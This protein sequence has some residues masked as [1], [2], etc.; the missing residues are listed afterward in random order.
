MNATKWFYSSFDSVSFLFFSLVYW[1]S[2][3]LHKFQTQ[4][5]NDACVFAVLALR[6]PLRK[7][8]KRFMCMLGNGIIIKSLL[9]CVCVGAIFAS[10]IN[11][12]LNAF[13]ILRDDMTPLSHYFDTNQHKINDANFSLRNPPYKQMRQRRTG[14]LNFH[15]YFFFSFRL[16]L[17]LVFRNSFCSLTADRTVALRVSDVW[18]C[19]SESN[20]RWWYIEN[21]QHIF[22]W[23]LNKPLCLSIANTLLVFWSLTTFFSVSFARFVS[24]CSIFD[25]E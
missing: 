13:N 5:R 6:A 22:A 17:I 10:T 1:T 16:M 24:A 23:L 25:F 18:L 15:I 2:S 8:L 12:P 9:F 11:N 3:F 21:N 19:A 4:S 14:C 7:Y 20:W